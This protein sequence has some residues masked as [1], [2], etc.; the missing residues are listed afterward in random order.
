VATENKQLCVSAAI[1]VT[2][3]PTPTTELLIAKGQS[4]SKGEEYFKPCDKL[5]VGTPLVVLSTRPKP[6]K[7]LIVEV[8][9]PTGDIRWV[10][11]YF[12]RFE[13]SQLVATA[14]EGDT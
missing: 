12:L 5:P 4:M 13:S 10:E 9:T 14:T 6:H 1:A 11:A 2:R 8:L 7:K 3:L